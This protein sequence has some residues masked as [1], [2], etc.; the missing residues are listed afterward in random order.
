MTRKHWAKVDRSERIYR[1][2]YR[3]KELSLARKP[4][5]VSSGKKPLQSGMKLGGGASNPVRFNDDAT[6]DELREE[7]IRSNAVLIESECV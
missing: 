1:S 4:R 3:V 7:I 6:A 2:M 5:G